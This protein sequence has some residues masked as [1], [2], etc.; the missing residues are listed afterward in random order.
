MI[1]SSPATIRSYHR[2]TVFDPE[3]QTRRESTE[4]SF[5]SFAGACIPFW[6][7]RRWQTKSSD[8]LTEGSG[9]FAHR[10]LPMGKK[11]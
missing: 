6:R 5:F 8:A 4:M 7:V 3:A 11:K 1:F 10:R 9:F 2:G